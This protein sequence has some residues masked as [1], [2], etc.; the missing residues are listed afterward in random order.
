MGVE[1]EMNEREIVAKYHIEDCTRCKNECASA[2]PV[3]RHFGAN[4]PQE[5]A[6]KF[7]AGGEGAAHDH[8]LIWT[9]VTCAAC[10]EAC[11]F[12]VEFADFIRE[13]RAGRADYRPVFG[14]IIHQYQKAQAGQAPGPQMGAKGAAP[15]SKAR[16]SWLDASSRVGKEGE[17]A[18]FAGC[19]ALFDAVSGP[20]CERRFGDMARSAV[21]L[22]NA[23]GV[24]PIILDDERCCGRDLYDLGE[25]EA[26]MALARHNVEEIAKSKART[27]LA[28]C[29]ECAFT[30][31]DTYAKELGPQPFEVRHITEFVAGNLEALGFKRGNE[32]LAFHD[33]CYLCRRLGES[34]APRKI[35]ERLSS[36]KPVELERRGRSA[37]CCG[38]GSW[39]DH[40]PH[41]R[42]AVSERLAEAHRC[43]ADTLVTA[44]PKCALLYHEVSPGC[45]WKQSPVAVK[46]LITLAAS[47]LE[48]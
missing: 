37:P 17:T 20:S 7:L 27:I 28:I 23:L 29:P 4:H 5:L 22:L 44:C 46:D 30:L 35:L 6:K 48:E 18:L 14:G 34:E 31:K 11:P 12:K 33:P 13:L 36:A 38:A 21:K 9:C 15:A 2:C 43:G 1:I 47:R 19:L 25:R 8:T 45:S 42:T 16:L 26:F 24:S 3:Y 39:V 41:T 40:G 32:K 10:T